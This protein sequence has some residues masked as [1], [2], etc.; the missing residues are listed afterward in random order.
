MRKLKLDVDRLAVESFAA[1]EERPTARGT[2]RGMMSGSECATGWGDATCRGF[3]S[4][5]PWMECDAT[6]VEPSCVPHLC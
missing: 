2:L 3:G 5:D 4:C 1:A 6:A